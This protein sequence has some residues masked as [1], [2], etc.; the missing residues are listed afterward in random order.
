ML[1]LYS[2]MNASL[3]QILSGYTEAELGVL[4]DF[5]RRTTAA[6]QA[7]TDNLASG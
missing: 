1:T 5:L 3:D 6:G 4:T 7:A 2:G